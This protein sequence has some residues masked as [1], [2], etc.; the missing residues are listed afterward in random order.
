[1]KHIVVVDAGHG[2][3][4]SGCIASNG[5]FEKNMNLQV[6]LYLKELSK[7]YSSEIELVLTREKDEYMGLVNKAT[8]ANNR[9]ANLTISIHHN[10]NDK[11]TRGAEVIHSVV[12]G[13]GK[14][15]AEILM[16]EFLKLGVKRRKVYS[17]ESDKYKGKDY[18]TIIAIPTMP[19]VISEFCFIDNAEDFKLM[20]TDE[21]RKGQAQAIL[22]SILRYFTT[23]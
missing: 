4:D 14:E 16:S 21:Q 2:G 18:F 17:K 10:A 12:G 19:T 22:N 20:T 15:F 7:E 9:N 11:K 3:K 1:V 5:E 6:A 23:N 13:K 8:F